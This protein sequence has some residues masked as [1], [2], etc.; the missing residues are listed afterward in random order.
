MRVISIIMGVLFIG[1]GIYCLINMKAAFISLAF[2]LGIIMMAYGIGQIV[3]WFTAR[4]EKSLSGWVALEG[5]L[6]LLIGALVC[7]YPFQTD[8]VI[9]IWF[10]AWLTV[11]GI[12]RVVAA[13]KTKQN[14]P[15]SPWGFMF[16]MGVITIIMGIYGVVHPLVAGMTVA[17]L[18]G[19]FFILQGVN[20]LVFGI[21]LP[22]MKK[23]KNE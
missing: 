3:S 5:I 15:G 16:F 13:V 6:T 4:K 8:V 2:I 12:M 21:S 9:A 19:L 14:Y 11:S 7:F 18:L 23:D 17:I 20:S 10:A 1:A 22:G